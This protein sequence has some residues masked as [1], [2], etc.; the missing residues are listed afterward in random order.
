MN[1]STRIA[2]LESRLHRLSQRKNR[3]NAGVRRKIN[4]EISNLKKKLSDE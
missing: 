4:R 1:I 3:D 2:F